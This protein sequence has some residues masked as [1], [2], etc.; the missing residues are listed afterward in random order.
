M[1]A[2]PAFAQTAGAAAG[3]GPTEMLM[4]LLPLIGLVVLFY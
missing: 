4:Q 2:T 1:F 3:G